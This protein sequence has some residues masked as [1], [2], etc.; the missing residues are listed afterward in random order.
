MQTSF[1]DNYD[2]TRKSDLFIACFLLLVL[3]VGFFIFVLPS[4]YSIIF[5]SAPAHK[6]S[7]PDFA[8]ESMLVI[9]AQGLCTG[10]SD[11]IV[12]D[13][14]RISE[15]PRAIIPDV[16]NVHFKCGKEGAIRAFL[17]SPPTTYR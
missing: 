16:I 1:R 15:N 9:S 14:I 2:G 12:M 10:L 17:W 11:P 4:V 5:K 7:G 13:I 8:Y 6:V 3:I